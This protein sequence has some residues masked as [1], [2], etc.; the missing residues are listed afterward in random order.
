MSQR[1]VSPKQ[2]EAILKL[3]G[4]ERYDHFIK[5]VADCEEAWGLWRDGWAMGEDDSGAPTFPIWPAKDYAALS[6]DGPWTGYEPASIPL[7]DLIN[8]LLP[9]LEEDEVKPSIFRTPQG[10]A[11]MPDIP[12]LMADLQR[13]MSRYE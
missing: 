8:E 1:V 4:P 5:H 12:Q 11:V 6:A 2:M 3:P 13:E 9:K 7:D 10:D